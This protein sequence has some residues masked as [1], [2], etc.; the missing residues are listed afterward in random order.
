M[1][2]TVPTSLSS[3]DVVERGNLSKNYRQ[4]EKEEQIKERKEGD[5]GKEKTVGRELWEIWRKKKRRWCSEMENWKTLGIKG[6]EGENGK[7]LKNE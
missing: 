6:I 7:G 5:W 4:K 3:S 1:G 2:Y